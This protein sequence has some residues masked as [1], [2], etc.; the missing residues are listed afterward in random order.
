M[1]STWQCKLRFSVAATTG[2]GY[3]E[4]DLPKGSCRCIRSSD[5][6]YHEGGATLPGVH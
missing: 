3:R 1:V 6:H 2:G 4:F 5:A